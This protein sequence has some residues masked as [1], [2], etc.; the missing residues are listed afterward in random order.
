MSEKENKPLEIRF[1][2]GKTKFLFRNAE[3]KK[4][5]NGDCVLIESVEYAICGEIYK[6]SDQTY[7][8]SIPFVTGFSIQYYD[9]FLKEHPQLK[10]KSKN[11]D[12]TNLIF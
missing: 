4:L 10:E 6:S 8:E 3:T 2:D 11:Y 1:P 5:K 7:G 9:K 12:I